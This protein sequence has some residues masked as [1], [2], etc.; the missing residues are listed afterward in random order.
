M[1]KITPQNHNDPIYT[2]PYKG[3]VVWGK[4]LSGK[5]LQNGSMVFALLNWA[6]IETEYGSYNWDAFE[7]QWGL[8]KLKSNQSCVLRLVLDYPQQ[9]AQSW[10][11]KWLQQKIAN[12]GTAYN[13]TDIG[14][15]FSP[16]YTNKY[17]IKAHHKFIAAIAARYDSDPRVGF[18][19]IGSLGHWGEWHTWPQGTGVFPK[20]KIAE[21]YLKHYIKSFK[22]TCLL[23]R[24]PLAAQANYQH[25][26][27][28]NDVLGD[29]TVSAA[30]NFENWIK[31]GYDSEWDNYHHPSMQKQW[32]LQAAAG[33]EFAWHKDG[34]ANYLAEDQLPMVLQQIANLHLSWI[35]PNNAA[36]LLTDKIYS[37]TLHAIYKMLGYR[38]EIVSIEHPETAAATVT[39][40]FTIKNTAIA[41]FYFNWNPVL[42][43]FD[44][45]Y[46]P[47]LTYAAEEIDIRK[48]YPGQESRFKI[49]VS[50]KLLPQPGSY[51]LGVAIVNPDDAD[52]KI[53]FA[54]KSI[55]E[56]D[57]AI[58]T[59]SEIVLSE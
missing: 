49:T 41:P 37:E 44:Q 8:L 36:E 45:Q 22:H 3:W 29:F 34:V 6:E 2:N 23:V 7:T 10:I 28:Y 15:G 32:W 1:I 38:F 16:D 47:V 21:K 59:F 58:L 9:Q 4:Y 42:Y 27:L 33:G 17:L 35:G 25:V 55:Y 31:Q 11:P 53:R 56:I 40:T 52:G 24:R 19:E 50:E 43:F 46:K 30:H 18:I 54:N 14:V 5:T 20:Y 48:W 26:G 57:E 39:V 51:I 13:H 12:Q